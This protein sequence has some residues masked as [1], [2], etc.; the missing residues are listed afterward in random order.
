MDAPEPIPVFDMD[1]A[2]C[3]YEPVCKLSV[4]VINRLTRKWFAF[5]YCEQGRKKNT[6]RNIHEAQVRLPVMEDAYL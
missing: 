4:K 1:C 6:Y 3:Q 5:N 2:R